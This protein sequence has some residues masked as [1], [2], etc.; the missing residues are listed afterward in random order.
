MVIISLDRTDPSRIIQQKIYCFY[1]ANTKGA[2]PEHL[3]IV[4]QPGA[5]G[6]WRPAGVIPKVRLQGKPENTPIAAS[7]NAMENSTR[8]QRQ[9]LFR[10]MA[11]IATA[12][13]LG[14][15]G[16]PANAQRCFTQN[17]QT[18]C[19]DNSGNCYSR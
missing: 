8:P 7:T 9:W 10:T 2:S 5:Q 17:G 1:L 6:L 13:A 3:R 14:L 16:A 11:L 15:L 4:K 18:I 19:C 12:C